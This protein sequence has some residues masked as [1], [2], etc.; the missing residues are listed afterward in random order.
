MPLIQ[1]QEKNA[2]IVAFYGPL[3]Q[4]HKGFLIRAIRVIR[5]FCLLAYDSL[6]FVHE[7][8]Q[9]GYCS[10]AGPIASTTLGYFTPASGFLAPRAF[11]ISKA[12]WSPKSKR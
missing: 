11:L 4:G 1:F 2:R 8:S 10:G 3:P 5:G 12:H 7:S 6:P 9:I